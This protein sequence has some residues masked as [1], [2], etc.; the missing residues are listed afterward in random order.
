[1]EG[2]PLT[3]LYLKKASERSLVDIQG[4]DVKIIF[5]FKITRMYSRKIKNNIKDRKV[6]PNKKCS[7]WM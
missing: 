4:C 5:T 7:N 6:F 3:K 1:M 2:I